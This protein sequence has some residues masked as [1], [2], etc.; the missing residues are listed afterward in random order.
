MATMG[1]CRA[2]L[3]ASPSLE[4]RPTCTD[5]GSTV[6][7]AIFEQESW[8]GWGERPKK[9][10]LQGSAVG[11]NPAQTPYCRVC[12][13]FNTDVPQEGFVQSIPQTQEVLPSPLVVI[14]EDSLT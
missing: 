3:R 4:T 8:V 9:L 13:G 12:I 5:R 10:C 6:F 14:S 11:M 1:I 7:K 2:C